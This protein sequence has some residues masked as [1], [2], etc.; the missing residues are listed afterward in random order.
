MEIWDLYDK[1]RNYLG[2][3]KKRGDVFMNGDYHIVTHICIFNSDNKMLIQLRQPYKKGWSGLWDITVGGSALHGEDSQAC[4]EREVFE[5][6]GYK[7]DLTE[8]RPYLTIHFTYGFDD[9]YLINDDFDVNKLVLQ[10][11]EVAAVK[12]ADLNEILNLID[13]DKFVPYHKSLVN[14]LFDMH[15]T[16]GAHFK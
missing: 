11:E 14:V 4:A 10:K 9:Y 7:L 2:K 5:E 15:K 6:I 1:N 13:N 8:Q 12:W 3:S 16:R